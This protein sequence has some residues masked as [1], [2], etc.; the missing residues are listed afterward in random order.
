M[1]FAPWGSLQA[2]PEAFFEPG[3]LPEG[4]RFLDPSKIPESMLV[5]FFRHVISMEHPTNGDV[6]KRFRFRCYEI[7]KKGHK[8][9]V[10]ALASICLS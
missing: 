8:R 3:M 4:F 1:K 10:D 5:S 9:L 7:G 2:R 6:A